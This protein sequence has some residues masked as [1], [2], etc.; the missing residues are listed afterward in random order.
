MHM[1]FWFAV[2]FPSLLHSPDSHSSISPAPTFLPYLTSS[3]FYTAFPSALMRARSQTNLWV[4]GSNS[5][6]KQVQARD[7]AQHESAKWVSDTWVWTEGQLTHSLKCFTKGR[8]KPVPMEK[9]SIRCRMIFITSDAS[10]DWDKRR[11]KGHVHSWFSLLFF[12][13]MET[14]PFSLYSLTRI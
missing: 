8:W 3:G 1:S 9:G 12:R 11:L 5:T 6:V 10:S 13:Y 7:S 2:P 14:P 4:V